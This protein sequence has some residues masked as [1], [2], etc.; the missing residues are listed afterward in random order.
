MAF[1][2]CFVSAKASTLRNSGSVLFTANYIFVP[3]QE[4]LRVNSPLS[5]EYEQTAC[6][7]SRGE[8]SVLMLVATGWWG[9]FGIKAANAHFYFFP[10]VCQH[11][12][13]KLWLSAWSPGF[14][15]APQKLGTVGLF[16]STL[17]A[18]CQN[19]HRQINTSAMF[20]LFFFRSSCCSVA[21]A[22]LAF[23]FSLSPVNAAVM[24]W[25]E[26]NK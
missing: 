23:F 22:T 9:C 8:T 25:Q 14:T 11:S 3:V 13:I 18:W 7:L 20:F 6:T 1:F 5:H 17:N 2:G 15:Y 4:A 24:Y 19:L 10:R 26:I 16:C 12:L 21:L